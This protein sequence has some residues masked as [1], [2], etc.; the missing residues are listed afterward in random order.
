MP[1]VAVKLLGSRENRKMHPGVPAIR[2]VDRRAV[3]KSD[4]QTV[5]GAVSLV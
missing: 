4:T 2:I 3:Y 1:P 5:R